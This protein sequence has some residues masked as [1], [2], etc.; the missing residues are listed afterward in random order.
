VDVKMGTKTVMVRI[1]GEDAPAVRA[2]LKLARVYHKVGRVLD[3]DVRKRGLSPAQFDMLAIVG[4]NEGMTQQEL[5]ERRVISK[6]NVT[7]VLDR[8]RHMRLISRV[9]EGKYNRLYLTEEGRRLLHE[10][11]PPHLRVIERQL[12]ALSPEE[13]SRL[14]ALLDKLEQTAGGAG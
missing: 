3:E 9:R 6:S 2:W 4:R 12:S 1:G 7:Q 11:T 10:V 14:L 13:Q 8:M 5:A